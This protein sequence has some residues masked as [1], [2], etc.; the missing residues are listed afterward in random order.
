MKYIIAP[1]T[2]VK[3]TGIEPLSKS[4]IEGHV[5]LNENELRYRYPDR[6][7]GGIVES[8]DGIIVDRATAMDFIKERKTVS[9]IKNS[10]GNE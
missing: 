3:G 2:T 5:V 10:I 4:V 6:S 8:I 7:L 9:Q 1:S